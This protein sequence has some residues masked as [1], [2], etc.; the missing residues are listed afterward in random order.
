MKKLITKKPKF[1]SPAKQPVAWF[2]VVT[3]AKK[4]PSA[5]MCS[6]KM[7]KNTPFDMQIM[8]DTNIV[9]HEATAIHQAS[10]PS[11]GIHFEIISDCLLQPSFL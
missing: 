2:A 6:R 10:K 3:K 7:T 9:V 8:C 4:D 1:Y 5:F 11:F